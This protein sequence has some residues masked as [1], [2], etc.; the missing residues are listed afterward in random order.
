MLNQ[1][2]LAIVYI[3]IIVVLVLLNY[4][5]FLKDYT[6]LYN[7][8]KGFLLGSS[9]LMILLFL[10]LKSFIIKEDY[11]YIILFTILY[12]IWYYLSKLITNKIS[13]YN[14]SI[15]NLI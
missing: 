1:T 10:F 11:S 13:G 12:T 6:S 8:Q 15:N 14:Y 2:I 9:L 7:I 5:P 3:S 4:L